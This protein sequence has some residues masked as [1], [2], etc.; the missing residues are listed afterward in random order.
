MPG[1]KVGVD[2]G[3]GMTFSSV[4][5]DEN[6]PCLIKARNN[7][8]AMRSV[9]LFDGDQIVV[10]EGTMNQWTN[11]GEQVVRWVKHSMGD[12]EDQFPRGLSLAGFFSAWTRRMSPDSPEQRET[13]DD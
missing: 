3:I 7:Q 6:R 11:D 5:D 4:A 10:G 12:P 8:Q 9:V 13:P 2:L 1:M